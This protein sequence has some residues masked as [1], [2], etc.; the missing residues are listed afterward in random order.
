MSFARRDL[1]SRLA[2][3]PGAVLLMCLISDHGARLMYSRHPVKSAVTCIPMLCCLP[4]GHTNQVVCRR[5]KRVDLVSQ[6]FALEA[7]VCNGQK[8]WC[9]LFF[10]LFLTLRN[11]L[12]RHF[13]KIIQMQYLESHISVLLLIM[14]YISWWLE[15]SFTLSTK[16]GF[17]NKKVWF[18]CRSGSYNCK[19]GFFFWFFF[20]LHFLRLSPLGSSLLLVCFRQVTLIFTGVTWDMMYKNENI[21]QN[22]LLFML[23]V[24]GI[25]LAQMKRFTEEKNKPFISLI[26]EVK[27][28]CLSLFILVMVLPVMPAISLW[29]S[30]T[31]MTHLLLHC[32]NSTS[33]LCI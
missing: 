14:F 9:W 24:C 23:L 29:L 32:I 26:I 13:L 30:V 6:P 15:Q 4:C 2:G 1:Q 17:I 31:F 16:K 22:I 33:N 20:S 21:D 3:E 28:L 7:P 10:E 8:F 18:L 5:L 25:L 12:Q 11:V 27:Q 19:W